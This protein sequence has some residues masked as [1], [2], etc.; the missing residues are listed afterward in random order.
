M[1]CDKVASAV[2]DKASRRKRLSL[3]TMSDSGDDDDNAGIQ[4]QVAQMIGPI[5]KKLKKVTKSVGS[6]ETSMQ[7]LRKVGDEII[8]ALQAELGVMVAKAGEK[9]TGLQSEIAR[10]AEKAALELA[11][12]EQAANSQ[13]MKALLDEQRSKL[14]AS[15][16]LVQS[17]E[18]RVVAMEQAMETNE[19]RINGEVS[20]AT[21]QLHKLGVSLESQRSEVEARTAEAIGRASLQ[22]D[23]L[24]ARLAQADDERREMKGALATKADLALVQAAVDRRADESA[25]ALKAVQMQFRTTANDLDEVR[26]K[27]QTFASLEALEKVHSRAEMISSDMRQVVV[28]AEVSTHHS[29]SQCRDLSFSNRLYS[30]LGLL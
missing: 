12:Q 1:W 19:A 6:L 11:L 8:P 4:A 27:L 18:S 5:S 9:I 22:H 15:E 3:A 29:D 13:R 28:N 30:P 2:P 23:G 16:L 10:C 7:D 17:L 26:T 21:A 20:S 24:L 25:T 14:A